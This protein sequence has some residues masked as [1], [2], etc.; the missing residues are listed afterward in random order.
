MV[1]HNPVTTEVP[2]GTVLNDRG[3]VPAESSVPITSTDIRT[4][5]YPES[6]WRPV[7]AGSLMVLSIFALSWYLML[8]CH[9]GTDA[10][11]YVDL[12]V[13]AA[14]WMCVTSCIAF[15][16]G[17]AAASAIFPN[18]V[19]NWTMGGAVWSLT[20]PLGLLILGLI[21]G[22]GGLLNHFNLVH[23]GTLS[24]G[25]S[26]IVGN[27][28]NSVAHSNFGFYWTGFIFLGLGLISSLFGSYSGSTVRNEAV[29]K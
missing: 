7:I 29:V 13:G 26:D 18:R 6:F 28:S 23:F 14:I 4:R 11:G 3:F 22:N 10:N 21:L 9:V 12:G 1:S 24:S 15:Y 25:T 27:T 16:I 5:Y 8:G 20:I 2:S 19:H 17:G